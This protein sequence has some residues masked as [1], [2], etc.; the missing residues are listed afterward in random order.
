MIEGWTELK[1]ED[2]IAYERVK[3]PLGGILCM[4]IIEEDE[5]YLGF[6]QK[7]ET[8]SEDNDEV[9]M[10]E[11][12]DSFEECAYVLESWYMKLIETEYKELIR[13]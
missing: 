1:N 8:F 9:F 5:K 3:A 7:G 11:D 6:I 10:V 4:T 2:G 13:N 12:M